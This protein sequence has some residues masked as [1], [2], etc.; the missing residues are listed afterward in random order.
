M[1]TLHERSF[2]YDDDDRFGSND[3]DVD[4]DVNDNVNAN[5]NANANANDTNNAGVLKERLNKVRSTVQ[6]ATQEA[7]KQANGHSPSLSS[8]Q[9][10]NASF[11]LGMDL[12]GS[13]R[14]DK[15]EQVERDLARIQQEHDAMS[16][17]QSG[18]SEF[19]G[20]RDGEDEFEFD[21]SVAPSGKDLD[22]Q[23]E[24]YRRK[25]AF[26]KQAS[27]A[28][29]C[30]E[31]SAALS[32]SVASATRDNLVRSAQSLL[33]AL[34]E[35]DKAEHIL[36]ESAVDEQKEIEVAHRIM[37]SLRH[38]IRRHR[39]ELVHKAG[40]VLDG[41]VELTATSIAVKSSPQLAVAYRVLETLDDGEISNHQRGRKKKSTALQETLRG[42]TT[43]LY[44]EALKPILSKTLS[45][46]Q[47]GDGDGKRRWKVEETADKRSNAIPEEE[48]KTF[49][50][51]VVNSWKNM[52]DALQRILVFVQS[53]VL[54]ERQALCSMVGKRLFGTPD[55][56]PSL[57]NLS[58]LGL[59]STML[60]ENDQGVLVEAMLDWL[61]EQCLS[62]DD[63]EDGSKTLDRVS[64]LCGELLESTLPFCQELEG[65]HLLKSD[66]PSR[67][68]TF[69]QNF[70]KHFVDNPPED[71]QEAALAVF[72]L[73]R[74]SISDTAKKL[75][76]LVRTTMDESVAVVSVPQDSPLAV[77]R[78][79]LY[80][81]AREMFSLFRSIIPANHGREV[82]N[83]PRTAAV[84][85]N[86]AVFL[87]H[88]CMTLGLEYKEKFPQVDDDDAR[89]KL[90]KQTCIFVDMVP[91]FRELADTSLNDMLDLQKHQLAEIVGSRITYFGQSLRSDESVHEWSEAE[92]A[93]A[94]GIYHLRHLAQAWKSI[95]SKSVFLR[96][97]GYLADVL[98]AL[99]LNEVTSNAAI[100]SGSARQFTG[101][102]FRKAT[103]DIR[104]L[105]FDEGTQLHDDPKPYSLEWGRFEAVGNFLELDQLVQ[106]EQ[107]LSSGVFRNVASQELARLVQATYRDSPQ[108]KAL[109]N[110]M[111]S[112]V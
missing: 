97:M 75:V 90:L 14:G 83:V 80:K 108:R 24:N 89:G 64:S 8:L 10:E 55:A 26:L 43:R 9:K 4:V 6:K 30:L 21:G 68:V 47:N 77:L 66:P 44:E 50:F 74:C 36:R 13:G 3:V 79:T 31:E 112:V 109:L 15:L 33:R 84:L 65:R 27:F 72:R 111:A 58:A 67:L 107:A 5:V 70:E 11:L 25:I 105:L 7:W 51:E 104:G 20:D 98:L 37:S 23:I 76:E 59:E 18:R 38:Q 63:G 103:I 32:S 99:Y 102:L 16:G 49:S 45:D 2:A 17:T 85:H 34:R 52:L 94:A 54:L 73:S 101:G 62:N 35:V 87:A 60:G 56:M 46:N 100:V 106:V 93:L 71:S 78:P 48:G 92:T 1:D 86:D 82:A 42:F 41:S 12:F 91:L 95:L 81:T 57:M 53:K 40:T 96:S 69:C 39:V 61:R 88:H 19:D 29:S 110:C 22:V 28:R